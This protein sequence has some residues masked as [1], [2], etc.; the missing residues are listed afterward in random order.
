LKIEPYA[1]LLTTPLT[2]ICVWLYFQPASCLVRRLWREA[3]LWEC[4]A[5]E[6]VMET[7]WGRGPGVLHLR[8]WALFLGLIVLFAV[9]SLVSLGAFLGMI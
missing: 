4:Q 5:W 6:R 1:W 7:E 8:R 3:V 2:L 9:T